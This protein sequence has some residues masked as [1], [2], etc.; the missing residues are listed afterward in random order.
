MKKR[1]DKEN[2]TW[3]GVELERVISA[4]NKTLEGVKPNTRILESENLRINQPST[5]VYVHTYRPDSL[6]EGV[7]VAH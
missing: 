6:D 4:D 5:Y 1:Q 7:I 3:V 2:Q